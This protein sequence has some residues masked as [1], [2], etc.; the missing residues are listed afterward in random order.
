MI[1]DGIDWDQLAAIT[2]SNDLRKMRDMAAI[3]VVNTLNMKRIEERILSIDKAKC[4]NLL[5]E[6]LKDNPYCTWCTFPKNLKGIENINEEITKI[7]QDILQILDEWTNLILDEIDSYRDNIS[8]LSEEQQQL[9]QKT[10]EDRK[11]PSEISQELITAL[12]NLFSEL[13]EIAISPNEII[14]YVFS[15]SS[16]LDY[17]AFSKKLDEYKEE[18]LSQGDKKNIRIMRKEG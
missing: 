9:I 10:I 7:N 15:E 17:E 16:V 18:M 1:G 11:L 6:H 3:K 12:N 8:L 14:N 5:E 13:T 2:R 4:T